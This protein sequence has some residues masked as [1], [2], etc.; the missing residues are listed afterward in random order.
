M[1]LVHV[2]IKLVDDYFGSDP[3]LCRTPADGIVL[4]CF[5]R[6]PEQALL[7]KLGVQTLLLTAILYLFGGLCDPIAL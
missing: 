1:D 7:L 5:S 2:V 4:L 6:A 3:G